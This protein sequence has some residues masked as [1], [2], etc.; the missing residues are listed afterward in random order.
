MTPCRLPARTPPSQGGEAG[1]TPVGATDRSV[2]IAGWRNGR[3]ASL[4]CSCPSWAWEFESPLGDCGRAGARPSLINSECWVR[5]PGQQ[6]SICGRVGKPAKPPVRETGACGFDS[7]SGYCFASYR[8]LAVRTP[9]S[10]AG[11]R[12]FESCR[13]DSFSRSAGVTAACLLGTEAVRVRVPSGPLVRGGGA[14]GPTARRLPC[15]QEVGVRLPGGPL[16]H[17]GPMVQ[18][19]DAAVARRRSGFD[20]RR[21]HCE[22]RDMGSWSNRRTPPWRGG[23]PGATPGDSTRVRRKASELASN[24]VASG[25]PL[26]GLWVRVPRL[27]LHRPG[28]EMEITS[29]S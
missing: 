29:R 6:L 7:H 8:R 21:V 4:R 25:A 1:S 22:Q 27:P 20:S 18:R 15:T 14:A 26:T 5:L 2:S 13:D 16:T 19:D 28:G 24:P 17:D 3:R 11:W 9:A 12:R 10:H 23:G